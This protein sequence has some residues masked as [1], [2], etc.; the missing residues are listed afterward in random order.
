MTQRDRLRIET[1]RSLM[2][3]LDNAGAVAVDAPPDALPKKGLGHDV[4]RKS[5]DEEEARSIIRAE[6]EDL[7]MATA[8]YR[9]LG[10]DAKADRFTARAAIVAAYLD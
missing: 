3:A 5:V 7:E 8:Q 10:Q 1:I 2:A 4:E 6:L 9:R